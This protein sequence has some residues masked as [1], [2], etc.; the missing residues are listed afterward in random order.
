MHLLLVCSVSGTLR[1]I[2]IRSSRPFVLS[3]A[4]TT[5][6]FD[7]GGGI[8]SRSR[9]FYF[10]DIQRFHFHFHYLSPQHC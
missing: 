5:A 2:V 1:I 8:P 10:F 6:A 9:S 7:G 3:S 4:A